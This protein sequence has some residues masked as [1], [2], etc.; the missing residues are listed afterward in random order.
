MNSKKISPKMY[1]PNNIF[2]LLIILQMIDFI[3]SQLNNIIRLGNEYFRFVHFSSNLNGDMIVD[4]SAYPEVDP[5]Y[6]ERRF[7]GLKSNGRF[8]FK[9]DNNEETPFASIFID[10][11]KPYSESCFIQLSNTDDNKEY[12]LSI[13]SISNYYAELYDLDKLNSSAV[14]MN[15]F[16]G[17]TGISERSVL[18]KY[19]LEDSI[20]YIIC[21]FISS[22]SEGDY[23]YLRKIYLES[24]NIV[25]EIKNITDFDILATSNK[26][27]ASCFETTLNRII[28]L[29]QFITGLVINIYDSSTDI[30]ASEELYFGT[31][32]KN[33]RIFFKGLLLKE[34]IGFFMYYIS[35]TSTFPFL[36]VKQYNYEENRMDNYKSY[37]Q[38][39]LT[40]VQFNPDTSLNDIIRINDNKI[41]IVSVSPDKNIIYIIILYLFDEDTK[42]M[43]NY[44]LINIFEKNKIKIYLDLRLFLYN[45][46]IAL[47]FSHCIEA[48]DCYLDEHTHYSSLI[49]FNYP[50][51][52]D[53]NLELIA[54]LY[55]NNYN[56]DQLYI[57]LSNNTI[58]ENNIFGYT[59]SGIK[60]IDISQD[61]NLFF[62]KNNSAILK[63]YIIS[64]EDIIKISLS[65]I[66]NE[67]IYSIEYTTIV[68]DPIF[69]DY[70]EY[71]NFNEY[72][73]TESMDQEEYYS[74]TEHIGKS[75]YY[76]I[77]I[78]DDEL[79]SQCSIEYCS[80][81]YN[82]LFDMCVLCYNGYYYNI[83]EDICYNKTEKEN[84]NLLTTIINKPE[85]STNL[86]EKTT[87]QNESNSIPN[88]INTIPNKITTISSKDYTFPNKITNIPNQITTIPNVDYTIQNE[89]NT[90]SKLIT[91]IPNKI[92]TTISKV[93]TYIPNQLTTIPNQNTTILNKITTIPNQ[94]S[95]SLNKITTIPNKINIIQTQI[96]TIPN[97][98]T[99]NPNII[100]NSISGITKTTINYSQDS[101][102]NI[103]LTNIPSEIFTNFTNISISQNKLATTILNKKTNLQNEKNMPLMQ[104]KS[105]GNNCSYE[106]I[107]KNKCNQKKT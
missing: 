54:Y 15:D 100:K 62:K 13:S 12:L 17:I 96:N 102:I 26:Y 81:C 6:K 24:L 35:N 82:S 38:I 48:T 60:I 39:T 91:N 25:N 93:I 41:C 46:F 7:F 55:Y 68:K 66:I 70:F 33:T 84:K 78:D 1:I 92:T 56:I 58:I 57:N 49:I 85:I 97:Q 42:M 105:F 10:K 63:D 53:T 47:G 86:N 90:I 22:Q 19:S 61:L 71:T 94:D 69:I 21:G 2:L 72:I 23:L 40:K 37:N 59:I 67:N 36:S 29:Y 87:I 14:L 31:I 76:N 9:D 74:Q 75:L 73:N 11:M 52:T 98:I 95:T 8:Y 88:D 83:N 3:S 106:D 4:T 5:I 89:I 50:N 77:I 79:T 99:T 65:D 30:L 101:S 28:C 18:F 20:N 51:N 44:Y 104:N 27:M 34:E 45:N 32:D 43:I 64:K 16:L 80:L 103:D 107:L